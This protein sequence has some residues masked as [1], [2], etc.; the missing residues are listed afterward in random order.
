MN[1]KPVLLIAAICT[2]V[3]IVVAVVLSLLSLSPYSTLVRQAD[4]LVE[5]QQYEEAVQKYKDAIWLDAKKPKAYLK[6]AEL[7]INISNDEAVNDI[8]AMLSEAYAANRSG[9]IE[10]IYIKIADIFEEKGNTDMAIDLLDKGYTTLYSSKLSEKKETL[11]AEVKDPF[12]NELYTA[13]KE[14]NI[15][16]IQKLI[17][18][19]RFNVVRRYAQGK[20]VVKTENGKG[21]AVYGDGFM[22]GGDF[23]GETREGTGTL[24]YEEE[25]ISYTYSG[26]WKNDK[27]NGSG[28]IKYLAKNGEMNNNLVSSIIEA[29]FT[30]GRVNGNVKQTDTRSD[31]YIYTYDYTAQNG[32]INPD[33]RFDSSGAV[34]VAA[35]SNE[36]ASKT[37]TA[38]KGSVFAV[39]G[40]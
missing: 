21:V 39:A 15:N 25:N 24:F 20:P 38:Q 30:D 4:K 6:L 12:I 19:A 10:E 1:K 37:L 13:Y 32:I 29:E 36:D 5:A 33:S 3:C 34:Y 8:H 31:G 16:Q 40:F 2:G 9:G 17:T 18:S 14:D 7:M 27:P 35:V 22:Y 28:V 23:S 11:V 26:S